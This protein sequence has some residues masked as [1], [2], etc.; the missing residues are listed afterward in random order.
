MANP[1]SSFTIK[2]YDGFGGNFVDSQYLGA[3]YE[4]GK[5]HIFQDT[6][7]RVFSSR[8][9]FFHGNLITSLTGGTMGVTEIDSEIYRW[10]LQGAEY[11][12]ARSMG[13]LAPSNTTKGL[14]GVEFRIWLDLDYFAS[15]DV[16][17]AED[18]DFPLEIV[19]GP[20]AYGGGYIY[21]VRIQGDNPN[22]FLPNYLVEAGREFDKSWTTIASEYNTEYGTQ[23]YPA[24]FKLES[25]I[26]FFGQKVTITD[27]AWR[28]QGK[29]NIKFTYEDPRTGKT[30]NVDKF[31]PMAEAKMHYELIRSMEAQSIYGK[32]Q[33]KPSNVSQYWKKTGSLRATHVSNNVR[34]ISLIAGTPKCRLAA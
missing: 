34:S 20:T 6:L 11:K 15:P 22:V 10:T 26:S 24:S 32:K 30:M 23:Q 19:A 3:S 9:R 27:K 28:D 18:N 1:K 2:H 25:Q 7:M 29:L 33:T 21:T 12:S 17:L 16:L 8:S 4:T 31:L 13:D 14:G 5:P